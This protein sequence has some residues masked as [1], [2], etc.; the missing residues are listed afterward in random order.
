MSVAKPEAVEL[1]EEVLN[2][3]MEVLNVSSKDKILDIVA[4]LNQNVPT[5]DYFTNLVSELKPLSKSAE[6]DIRI[7]HSNS[8]IVENSIKTPAI[9]KGSYGEI[10]LSVK[11]LIYKKVNLAFD[12]PVGLEMD[13][14]E[15]F[16]ETF[17]QTVLSRDPE[18]GS[19]IAHV[20]NMYRSAETPE[21]EFVIYITMENIPITFDK[22]LDKRYKLKNKPVSLTN[23]FPIFLKIANIL[24]ILQKKYAFAHRDFHTGNVMFTDEMQVKLIDF[25]KSCMTHPAN[26]VTYSLD[27]ANVGVRVVRR[28]GKPCESYDLLIFLVSL[29]EYNR[30]YLGKDVETVI[31]KALTS[32]GGVQF[33]RDLAPFAKDNTGKKTPLFHLMYYDRIPE[34]PARLRSE[35]LTNTPTLNPRDFAVFIGREYSAALPGS[36]PTP[37]VA[38]SA[39]VRAPSMLLRYGLPPVHARLPVAFKMKGTHTTRKGRKGRK[40]RN[41]QKTRKNIDRN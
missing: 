39:L 22:L 18:I 16:L 1:P 27:T 2:A 13:T 38:S 3:Y 37:A 5:I 9:G 41:G 19:N 35:L 34:W 33:M 10:Y 11:G 24:D 12:N 20:F 30:M 17:L 32:R 29:L 23:M 36:L 26:R 8:F 25:G 15:L 31:L 6:G 40:G 28:R 4:H 7:A 14:R 21:S